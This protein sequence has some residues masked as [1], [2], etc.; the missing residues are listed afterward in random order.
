MMPTVV[1]IFIGGALGNMMNVIEHTKLP[2]AECKDGCKSW[3]GTDALW[4]GG[5]V[6]ADAANHCAQPGAVVNDHRNGAWCMCANK[7]LG[8]AAGDGPLT[9]KAFRFEKVA[10][11]PSDPTAG[12]WLSFDGQN[13][14]LYAKDVANSSIG[15]WYLIPIDDDPKVMSFYIQNRWNCPSERRCGEWLGFTGNNM[16][17]DPTSD[18]ADKVMWDRLV[19]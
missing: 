9:D 6:P 10:S 13:A 3:D 16:I 8:G 1:L 11:G 2:P 4:L 5:K 18:T 17:L 12:E 19:S 14:V 15:I 7:T